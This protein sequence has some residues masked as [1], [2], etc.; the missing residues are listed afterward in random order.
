MLTPSAPKES[1]AFERRIVVFTIAFCVHLHKRP[2]EVI[3]DG[4]SGFIKTTDQAAAAH[5]ICL[6]MQSRPS[7]KQWSWQEAR[8]NLESL[9]S[10]A[11]AFLRVLCGLVAI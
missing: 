9:S 11:A 6:P 5:R 2:A 1:T 4:S 8:L 3:F 7:E 10:I